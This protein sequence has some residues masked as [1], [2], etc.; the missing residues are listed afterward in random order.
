MYFKVLGFAT[1]CMLSVVMLVYFAI[2]AG[3]NKELD[4]IMDTKQANERHN[5]LVMGTDKDETRSDVMMICSVSKKDNTIN[6]MSVPRDAR[7]YTGQTY[8][9]LNAA[10]GIGGDEFAIEKI[11]ELTG[12]EIHDYVKVNFNAVVDVIDA[13][14]GVKFD[15]PQNMDYDDP[16]Q[17]LY[18]HI[19]KGMQKLDGEKSL[20]LLRFRQYPMG[21]LQRIQVQQSFVKEIVKQKAKLR[22]ILKAK[23]IY[24]AAS[25]N[26]I[27]T[28]TAG[29]V[30]GLAFG[31]AGIKMEDVQTF[32]CPYHFSQSGIY[33]IIDKENLDS[34]VE[35]NFK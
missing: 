3:S 31:L 25:K 8:Q 10:I 33:V 12:M 7:I 17:D 26:M 14:G 34:I 24:K 32:E 15:V 35:E 1:F 19:E 18:I 4:K 20:Q 21:D 30:S 5:I 6:I 22:Y 23:K 11:K 16:Y 29:D 27:T 2:S 13:L 9:K 28:L